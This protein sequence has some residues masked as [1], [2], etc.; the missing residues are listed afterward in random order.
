MV[1]LY[2]RVHNELAAVGGRPKMQLLLVEL[3][4]RNGVTGNDPCLK[5]NKIEMGVD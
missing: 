1:L 3:L 4:R 2:A 5:A